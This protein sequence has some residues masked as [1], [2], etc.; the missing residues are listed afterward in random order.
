MI[1]SPSGRCNRRPPVDAEP[2]DSA[3]DGRG[4]R[5]SVYHPPADPMQNALAKTY[6]VLALGCGAIMAFVDPPFQSPDEP[7]HFFRAMAMS[8][9]YWLA[10]RDGPFVGAPMPANVIQWVF[11]LYGD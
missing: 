2:I 1:G 8:R 6:L 11:A 9:G 5:E 7:N 4:G 3:A 10:R